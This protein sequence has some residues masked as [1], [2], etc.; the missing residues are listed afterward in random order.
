[1]NLEKFTKKSQ[2]VIKN[3]QE[4]ALNKNHSHIDPE[5]LFYSMLEEPD[6]IVNGILNKLDVNPQMMKE[7]LVNL[8]QKKPTLAHPNQAYLSEESLEW[9]KL[10]EEQARL[11]KDEYISL[12]HFL[13]ALTELKRG[14]LQELL[15]RFSVTYDRILNV[16]KEVRGNQ[17]IR[18]DEPE[19]KMDV[20]EKY[21]R[22]LTKLAANGKLDPVI[23]R[24]E[25]LR[26]LIKI[27]SRRTKNN[28][29][30]IGEPGVGKTAVVE[31]LAHKIVKGEVPESLKGKRVAALDLAMLLAG[32]KYR[33]EFE[34]R[35]K[36]F[37]KEVE[38]S[39]GNIILFIDELHTIVGAGSVGG[40]MDASNMLKPALARG[41]LRAIGATTIHL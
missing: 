18:D 40:S 17:T 34:E 9:I 39:Q 2:N 1:M 19:T 21:S 27:L 20:L 7:E 3:A 23:G 5:H 13:L 8:L 35:L 12:E 36:A 25:E 15:K 32:T 24:E 28:P 31:G 26:R 33:G 30:L 37:L 38:S 16:L 4:L 29:V 14:V 11:L 22:D 10:T 41:E 6:S